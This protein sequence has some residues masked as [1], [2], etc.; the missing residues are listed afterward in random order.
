MCLSEKTRQAFLR[1]L[2]ELGMSHSELARRLGRSPQYVHGILR[3]R[4]TISMQ[5]A[6]QIAAL[7]S[8]QITIE[9]TPRR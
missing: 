7:L 5:K 9:L 3:D 8:C 4:R 6:D 1:R 2:S